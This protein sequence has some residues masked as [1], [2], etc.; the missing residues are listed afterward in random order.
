MVT[1]PQKY[2]VNQNDAYRSYMYIYIGNAISDHIVI[3]NAG[4]CPTSILSMD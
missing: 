2:F 1:G 3:V 4:A